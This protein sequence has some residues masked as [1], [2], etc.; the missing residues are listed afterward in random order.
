V[1]SVG[2]VVDF[3]ALDSNWSSVDP[4]EL[5]KPLASGRRLRWSLTSP[6]FLPKFH[7]KMNQSNDLVA[8]TGNS[9]NKLSSADA[10]T[11]HVQILIWFTCATTEMEK[12][13]MKKL[14][15]F[16]PEILVDSARQLAKPPASESEETAL[17]PHR[18]LPKFLSKMHS[19][20]KLVYFR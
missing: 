18:I 16:H 17:V 2:D 12:S 6:V 4:G 15:T 5:A 8:Q 3:S 1:A 9:T 11:G 10:R 19:T 14:S 20:C 13:V 7:S